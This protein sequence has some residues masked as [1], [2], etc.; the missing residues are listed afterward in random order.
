MLSTTHKLL[1][2]KFSILILCF[3]FSVLVFSQKN[4][5]SGKILDSI[6]QTP[7]PFCTV[8]VFSNSDSS[9][10]AGTITDTL[11]FFNINVSKNENYFCYVNYI[12][13]IEKE[14]KIE[15][16]NKKTDI[17]TIQLMQKSISLNQIQI[18]ASQKTKMSVDKFV[19]IIDSTDLFKAVTSLDVLKKIPDLNVSEINK[20]ISIKGKNSSLVLI[21]G[22]NRGIGQVNLLSINP[23]DIEKVEV[24]YSPASE[25]DND[26]D[27]VINIVLK[28]NPTTGI[29]GEFDLT[30]RTLTK[31]VEPSFAFQY[32][33]NKTRFSINYQPSYKSIP[34]KTNML[35]NTIMNDSLTYQY[36]SIYN[37]NDRNE[38]TNL[39]QGSLDYYINSK[40]FINFFI[41]TNLSNSKYNNILK[42]SSLEFD[43]VNI[44]SLNITETK[45]NVNNGTFYYKRNFIRE[46]QEFTLN[47]N[48]HYMNAGYS[49]SYDDTVITNNSKEISSRVIN[50]TGKKVSNNLKVDYLYPF[51]K[52]I[53]ISTGT[54][55]YYQLFNYNSS[56]ITS[57]NSEILKNYKWHYYA[58]MSIKIK[59]IDIR[60]GL[61]VE[62]YK[63][64]LN[65]TK[66]N[67][68]VQIL[69]SFVAFSQLTNKNSLRLSYRK[70]AYY[71]SSWQL[72]PS[73]IY[74][75]PYNATQ[76][77]PA[78]SPTNLDKFIFSHTYRSNSLS[79]TS[80][81]YYSKLSNMLASVRYVDNQNVSIRKIENIKG[82]STIGADFTFNYSY[83]DIFS[84]KPSL[85]LFR[86][87]INYYDNN[88]INYSYKSIINITYNLMEQYT[89]GIDISLVGKELQVQGFNY[90]QSTI[91][92]IYI[93]ML[94]F[95]GAGALAVGY[96]NPFFDNKTKSVIEDINF[97][98][99]Y[100]EKINSQ[101]FVISFTYSFAKGIELKSMKRIDR[102]TEKDLK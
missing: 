39:I 68:F 38:F 8:R 29:S 71:P 9:F 58:D 15:N 60:L 26:V 3:Q 34:V 74:S 76:G 100:T 92:D 42:V 98:Q 61:K 45:Y 19:Y 17:G 99:E 32:G 53:K 75:D 55:F 40:N 48:V 23:H 20:S 30:Y 77:N 84:I 50:E 31:S 91:E 46:G 44:N 27:G 89:F 83:N 25:Y 66:L 69:P 16:R 72:M 88:R 13:Y 79:L 37:S 65:N 28:R 43:T 93:Q 10:Y 81:L 57:Q 95:K 54:L 47:N 101:C 59:K 51:N 94:L 85:N 70:T 24:I 49:N 73:I 102:Q 63:S 36:N 4:V 2:L 41:E 35:R 12:G 6:S 80:S 97:Y 52:S 33:S 11:G 67:N 22:I 82:K 78:L 5:I 96:I 87:W 90:T 64:V 14:I 1:P 7:L 62:N 56:S 86:E 21:N 18:N